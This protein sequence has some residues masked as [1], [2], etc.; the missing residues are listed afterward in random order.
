MTSRL[1]RKTV[2][3]YR[4][5]RAPL[6]LQYITARR[7]RYSTYRCS[8]AVCA[9]MLAMSLPFSRERQHN[10]DTPTVQ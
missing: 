5:K 3:D 2:K 9:A 4:I 6:P 10:D 7:S 8:A 1:D